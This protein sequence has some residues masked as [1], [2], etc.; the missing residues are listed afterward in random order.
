MS[1]LVVFAAAGFSVLLFLFSAWLTRASYWRIAAALLGG[2]AAAFLSF[3]V[4]IAAAAFGW[5]TYGP[6][7]AHAPIAAYAPVAFW[8]GGGLGLIG[9]RMMRNWGAFGEWGFFIAFV[10]LGLTRDLALAMGGIGYEL[11]AGPLPLAI[12][13]A[14]W[15]VI[16]FLVQLVMQLLVGPIDADALG[17][18]HMPAIDE[19][20]W[21]GQVESAHFIGG[22]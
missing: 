6:T 9:W 18:E 17:A 11:A 14:T 13:A 4:D 12:S 20:I 19:S 22:E 16:A 15:F 7:E 5:W 2:V 1:S 10:L 3:G 8:F 21:R